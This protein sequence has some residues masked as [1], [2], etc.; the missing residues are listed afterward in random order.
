VRWCAVAL[1]LGVVAI[2]SA[3]AQLPVDTS[4]WKTL[5]EVALGFELKH[6]PTWRVGR[7]AGTL[8]SVLLGEP[9]QVGT[10]RVSMQVFVQR[11]VNPRGLSI[12]QWYADQLARLKVTAPPPTTSTV[13]GG[14]PTIR[15]ELTRGDRRHYDFYTAINAS[16]V[17]QVSITQPA[18]ETRLD[19]TQEAVLSTITFMK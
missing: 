11:A 17:F 4:G 9:V 1:A 13:I 8:E 15:R 6:P 14:R 12:E 18:A 2:V 16:D 3:K 5:R 7:S 10:V 19:P